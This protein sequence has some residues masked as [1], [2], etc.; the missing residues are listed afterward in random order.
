[1]HFGKLIMLGLSLVVVGTAFAEGE[2]PTDAERRK[3]VTSKWYVDQ[4]VGEKQEALSGTEGSIAV[5]TGTEGSLTEIAVSGHIVAT[6]SEVQDTIDDFLPTVGAVNTELNLRQDKLGAGKTAGYVATYTSTDGSLDQ[7]AVYNTSNAYDSTNQ[8]A[9]I[10]AAHA[11]SA[12]QTG[13]DRHLTCDSNHG[14]NDECWLWT[15]NDQLTTDIYTD[16]GTAANSNTT[17]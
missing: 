7:K 1:M 15:V 13:L 16:Y 17:N 10:E 3:T 2:A 14:P 5:Y 12:I 4:K 6:G 11:N 8:A 9:L